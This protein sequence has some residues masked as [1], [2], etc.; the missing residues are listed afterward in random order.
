M[1][2][3]QKQK[4]LKKKTYLCFFYSLTVLVLGVR[5]LAVF[6]YVHVVYRVLC[7]QRVTQ[8]KTHQDSLYLISWLPWA[9]SACVHPCRH[10]RITVWISAALTF[11]P[12]PPPPFLQ[13]VPSASFSGNLRGLSFMCTPQTELAVLELPPAYSPQESLRLWWGGVG[14]LSCALEKYFLPVGSVLN[15]TFYPLLYPSGLHVFYPPT[16]SGS[17][18]FSTGLLCYG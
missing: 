4:N 9:P 5:D 1:T 15:F 14:V 8:L 13:K 7:A 10:C 3:K 11:P 18:L 2:K 16:Q 17:K 12:P 6:A